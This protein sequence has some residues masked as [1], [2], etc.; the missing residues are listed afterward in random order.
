MG[1]EIVN[2]NVVF[3]QGNSANAVPD[4][5]S[6]LKTQTDTGFNI[7]SQTYKGVNVGTPT[8]G[9]GVL[10]GNWFGAGDGFMGA[11]NDLFGGKDSI[12]GLTGSEALSGIAS[13]GQLGLGILNYQDTSRYNDKV[14]EG[15]DQ[16]LANSRQEAKSTADY[17]RSYGQ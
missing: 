6:V 9:L 13:I 1:Y 8:E 16:N 4:L 11:Q 5:N 7:P 10:N 17:R 14:I 12:T 2:G 3:T 15:L